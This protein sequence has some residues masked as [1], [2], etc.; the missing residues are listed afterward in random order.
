M[1]DVTQE[2]GGSEFLPVSTEQREISNPPLL[3]TRL[4]FSIPVFNEWNNGM[5]LLNLRSMLHQSVPQG[6]AI[7]IDYIIN[8]GRTGGV[9]KSSQISHDTKR[10]LLFLERVRNTQFLA[11]TKREEDKTHLDALLLLEPDPVERD[12]LRLAAERSD[13]IAI[14]GVDISEEDITAQGYSNDIVGYRNIGLDYIRKRFSDHNTGEGFVVVPYDCDTIPIERFVED[15]I[16]L[17]SQNPDLQ[18]LFTRLGYQIPYLSKSKL[19]YTPRVIAENTRMYNY[20]MPGSPQL[21]FRS[22]HLTGIA[23][24]RSSRRSGE[25]NEDF[26]LAQDLMQ[27]LGSTNTRVTS[28]FRDNQIP[29]S[30]TSERAGGLADSFRR[31]DPESL[32][33]LDTISQSLDKLTEMR[34]EVEGNISQ[35]GDEMRPKAEGELQQLRQFYSR[36]MKLQQRFYRGIAN[37]FLKGLDQSDVQ[38]NNDTL[39]FNQD[40]LQKYPHGIQLI[41]FLKMN[42]QLL[43]KITPQDVHYVQYCLGKDSQIPVARLSDFQQVIR[44]F[45]GEYG[46]IDAMI[47]ADVDNNK[48]IDGRQDADKRSLVHPLMAE[49]MALGAI[50]FQ[51]F[52]VG[53]LSVD[54]NQPKAL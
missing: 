9:N 23:R 29:V 2:R 7:E 19:F 30:L 26:M 13:D 46:D 39:H 33:D 10:T 51:Y 8:N 1:S 34:R 43:G 32:M 24:F 38:I 54:R 18:Y 15:L 14:S 21:S 3:N 53:K 37:Q 27:H 41:Q 36:L 35:M 52:K 16:S 25:Y 42:Q 40:A 17:Y 31:E 11:R 20:G 47:N 28:V 44:E 5:F 12:I 50:D 49:F 22:P 4:V 6:Q 45:L 48:M